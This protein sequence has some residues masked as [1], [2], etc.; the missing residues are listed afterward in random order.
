M[1]PGVGARVGEG[2]SYADLAVPC[3]GFG[4]GEAAVNRKKRKYLSLLTAQS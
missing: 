2:C 1:S 3:Q 4:V